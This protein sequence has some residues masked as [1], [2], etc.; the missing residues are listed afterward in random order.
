SSGRRRAGRHRRQAAQPGRGPRPRRAPG[1][2]R[3][4]V[5]RKTPGRAAVLTASPAAARLGRTSPAARRLDSFCCWQAA[6]WF[7]RQACL[8]RLYTGR[9]LSGGVSRLRAWP[10]AGKFFDKAAKL[11]YTFYKSNQEVIRSPWRHV[12]W[13]AKPRE[14]V[15]VKL[16]VEG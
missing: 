2:K 15:T 6:P 7:W 16:S 4:P 1:T 10:G 9:E 14:S 8:L 12:E 3:L 11:C 5:S 13:G